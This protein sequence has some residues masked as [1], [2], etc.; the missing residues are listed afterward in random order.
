MKLK[1]NEEA[2]IGCGACL[3]IAEDVFELNDD[4]LSQ[5]KVA[6]V[7]EEAQAQAME[8]VESCPTAAIVEVKEE[9]K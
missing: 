4:G 2:C 6:E 1:V 7:P 9:E 3:A 8:A 5:V